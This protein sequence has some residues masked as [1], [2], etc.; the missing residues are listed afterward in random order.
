MVGREAY[1]IGPVVTDKHNSCILN[2]AGITCKFSEGWQSLHNIQ[3]VDI[4]SELRSADVEAG[5]QYK[6]KVKFI[7]IFTIS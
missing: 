4:F 5:E 6:E 2:L 1:G 7:F 3:K